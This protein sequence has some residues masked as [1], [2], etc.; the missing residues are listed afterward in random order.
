MGV[1][2]PL[3]QRKDLPEAK[4]LDCNQRTRLKLINNSIEALKKEEKSVESVIFQK[5]REEID[6]LNA[7]EFKLHQ[8]ESEKDHLCGNE[9]LSPKTPK[10][11]V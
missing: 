2:I 3:F 8:L 10:G 6:R 9:W 1:L 4:N 7:I 11:L 5:C